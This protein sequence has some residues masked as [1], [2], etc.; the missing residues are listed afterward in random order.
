[1]NGRA[2]V[3]SAVKWFLA[4]SVPLLLYVVVV[5]IYNELAAEDQQIDLLNGVFSVVVAGS[6]SILLL[7]IYLFNRRK[8]E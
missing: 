4:V 6:L 3:A 8:Q 5:S 7:W 2:R 1:M